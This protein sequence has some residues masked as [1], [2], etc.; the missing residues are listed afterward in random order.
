MDVWKSW[1]EE[2]INQGGNVLFGNVFGNIIW[3]VR[4][5]RVVKFEIKLIFGVYVKFNVLIEILIDKVV[6]DLKVVVFI[7]GICIFLQCGF[8]YRV[9][10][11]FNE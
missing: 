11:I 7:K 6:K 2:Y 9:L 3:I 5:V 1:M 8:L 10:M 4:K